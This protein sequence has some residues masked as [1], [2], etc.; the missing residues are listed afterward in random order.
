MRALTLGSP[1]SPIFY[2]P[3]QRTNV[4]VQTSR[5]AKFCSPQDPVHICA[6]GSVRRFTWSR[7]ES[8]FIHAATKRQ[9]TTHTTQN[10][11]I[12]S[13]QE[14]VTLPIPTTGPIEGTISAYPSMTTAESVSD[15]LSA[16]LIDIK[17]SQK[18][19]D[20]HVIRQ[21]SEHQNSS[22]PEP[23]FPDTRLLTGDDETTGTEAKLQRLMSPETAKTFRALLLQYYSNS[24]TS[25]ISQMLC[26]ICQFTSTEEHGD[27]F[28]ED[29]TFINEGLENW[30]FWQPFVEQIMEDI[31]EV[32]SIGSYLRLP[33]ASHFDIRLLIPGFSMDGEERTLSFGIVQSHRSLLALHS[34][35]LRRI[36]DQAPRNCVI[37]I[38]FPVEL[39][40]HVPNS[41]FP[42]F[43]AWLPSMYETRNPFS[44][45]TATGSFIE[46]LTILDLVRFLILLQGLEVACENLIQHVC[47]RA[48]T[49]ADTSTF[50]ALALLEKEVQSLETLAAGMDDGELSTVQVAQPAIKRI[51]VACSLR[52]QNG[53]IATLVEAT[54]RLVETPKHII[55]ETALGVSHA[56]Q[57]VCT[58][59]LTGVGDRGEVTRSSDSQI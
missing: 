12:T 25:A 41:L 40:P 2:A 39:S 16:E 45:G 51:P 4:G 34:G 7:I 55:T 28:S 59:L 13:Q 23:I 9:L 30:H 56:L 17:A 1:F 38:S 20:F 8:F 33:P 36:I 5:K 14:L 54:G 29:S 46:K 42:Y 27:W 49:H 32:A 15:R 24:R 43:V 11:R 44:K 22:P 35:R 10:E 47:Q 18:L 31:Q 19:R 48:N 57:A 6:T 37:D 50:R 53:F 52:P 58:A 21:P 26:K 3:T